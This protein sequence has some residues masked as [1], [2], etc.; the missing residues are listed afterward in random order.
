MKLE[1]E[2]LLGTL[3]ILA[4]RPFFWDTE[5]WGKFNVWNLM[6]S[7]GCVNLTDVEVALAEPSGSYLAHWQN[8]EH[9]GT[10]TNQIGDSW[11]YAPLRDERDD[12]WNAEIEAFRVERY[13]QLL[14]LLKA[15]LS[16][17]QAFRLTTV[18]HLQR[19]YPD[20]CFYIL[21]GKTEDGDWFCLSPIVPDQVSDYD[22]EPPKIGLKETN[23]LN[24]KTLDLQRKIDNILSEIPPIT[25]YGYYGGGYDYTYEHQIVYAIADSKILAVEKALQAAQ[26]LIVEDSDLEFSSDESGDSRKLCQFF[27]DKLGDPKIYSLSFW[28]IGYIF[29]VAET[30]NGDWLGVQKIL[31]FDYNP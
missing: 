31:E 21:I 17:L 13:Q 26:M 9:W 19:R 10:P 30:P 22:F 12:D 23:S 28:D 5:K 3:E 4:R 11:E 16:D 6:R 29:E 8:V 15:E 20:F 27:I 24:P 2:K 25:L 18:E 14:T 7:E 1:T